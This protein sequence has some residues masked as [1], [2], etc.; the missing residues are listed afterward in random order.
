MS[1]LINPF[2][3]TYEI[4]RKKGQIVL[5]KVSAVAKAMADREGSRLKSRPEN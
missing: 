4:P 5:G 1:G 2:K 3:R